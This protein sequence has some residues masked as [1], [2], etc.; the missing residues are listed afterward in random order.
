MSPIHAEQ[1]LTVI[2]DQLLPI[3]AGVVLIRA[4]GHS[5]GS[6]MIF[7][8]LEN[9]TELLL[10]GDAVWTTSAIEIGSQKPQAV[11]SRIG[12][13]V[14]LLASQIQWLRSMRHNGLDVIV[15]HDALA[16]NV[17][18]EMGTIKEGIDLSKPD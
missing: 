6:Q 5:A 2:Y 3:A 11:S 17:L 13:D 15:S 10:V 12:E 16:L 9:G 18:I 1:F 8:K 7:V 14:K 4:P